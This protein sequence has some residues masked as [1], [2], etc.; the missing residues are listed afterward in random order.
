[1]R[2]GQHIIFYDNFIYRRNRRMVA[3]LGSCYKRYHAISHISINTGRWSDNNI[4][5][6]RYFASIDDFHVKSYVIRLSQN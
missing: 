1:M 2:T 4:I 3:N 5:S 6:E